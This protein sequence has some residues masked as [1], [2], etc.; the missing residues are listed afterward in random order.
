MPVIVIR[1]N[2]SKEKTIF[3]LLSF[4]IQK[5]ENCHND[6]CRSGDCELTYHMNGT[7]KRECHCPKVIYF[8]SID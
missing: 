1:F 6:D 3:F 2:S 4:D 8:Y 7:L 5:I